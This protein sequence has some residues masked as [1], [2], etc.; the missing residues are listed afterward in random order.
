MTNPPRSPFRFSVFVHFV[1]ALF[2]KWSFF[3]QIGSKFEF[4]VKASDDLPWEPLFFEEA[5]TQA[6]VFF[7]AQMNLNL[8][9]QNIAEH[10]VTDLQDLLQRNSYPNAQEIE[11]LVTFRLLEAWIQF[12]LDQAVNPPLLFKFKVV[13]QSP[14]ET[15]DVFIS[16]WIQRKST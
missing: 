14:N 6:S 4:Q 16:H 1:R 15:N 3:E 2:P 12:K 11:S 10:F 8:A 7:N 9:Q 13:A 5:T